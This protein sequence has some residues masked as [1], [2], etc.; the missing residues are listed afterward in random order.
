MKF[1]VAIQMDPMESIDMEADSSFVLA[2]EAQ[3]RGYAL[4][5]YLPRDLSLNEGKVRA[6]A[7]PLSVRRERGRVRAGTI[8]GHPRDRAHGAA[9]NRIVQRPIAKA[10]ALHAEGHRVAALHGQQPDGRG[11]QERSPG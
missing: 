1:S 10:V 11:R 9:G 8:P 6:R 7:R 4:W 3:A 5:H 2:L